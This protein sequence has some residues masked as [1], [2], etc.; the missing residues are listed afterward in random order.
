MSYRLSLCHKVILLFLLLVSGIA[1]AETAF[2]SSREVKVYA[3]ADF[4][5]DKIANFQ[6]ADE[7][8]VLDRDGIWIEVEKNGLR[9][10]IS[11]YSISSVKPFRQK[12]S[13]FSRL[14]NFFSGENKRDRLALVSTAGGVRGLTEAE[15]D[16][17]GE[18][19]FAAVK[20]MEAFVFTE[21]DL[22]LFIAGD[23]D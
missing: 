12:V 16:E 13:I 20:R 7:V 9:G 19:D 22:D 6:T 23:K 8:E 18:T 11:R 10:W 2:V 4:N 1:T 15:S 21:S 17:T 3:D 5:S 14:K